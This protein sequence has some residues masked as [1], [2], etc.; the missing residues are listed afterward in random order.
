MTTAK[1]SGVTPTEQLL[2]E[3]GERSFLKL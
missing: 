3:F 1:S 2:A